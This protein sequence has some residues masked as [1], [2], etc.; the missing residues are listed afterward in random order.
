MTCAVESGSCFIRRPT[1]S[2]RALQMLLVLALPGVNSHVTSIRSGAGG[3]GGGGGGGGGATGGGGG[4]M[5]AGGGGGGGGGGMTSS[6]WNIRGKSDRPR[7]PP[8]GQCSSMESS[9]RR[10][11]RSAKF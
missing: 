2:S 1:S 6:S 11:V 7:R 9:C 10:S 5:S 4:G 8:I 3:A